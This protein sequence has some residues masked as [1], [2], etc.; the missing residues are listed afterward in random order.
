MTGRA[1]RAR[2]HIALGTWRVRQLCSLGLCGVAALSGCALLDRSAAVAIDRYKTPGEAPVNSWRVTTPDGGVVIF[3]TTRSFTDARAA[4]AAI[5]ATRLPV[6]GIFITHGHADHVTGI[7]IYR[8][9][10]PGVKVYASSTTQAY[11]SGTGR[12]LMAMNVSYRGSQDAAASVP[13]PDIL[14]SD[15]QHLTI[16][17]LAIDVHVIGPGESPDA[18]IYEIPA[19]RTVVV[20][21]LITR[22]RE[23]LVAEGRT[24][25]WLASIAR[26][27]R[28]YP[29]DES[30]LPGHGPQA[31]LG[32]AAKWQTAYLQ[33]YRA[34]ISRAIAVSSD[35]GRCVTPSET[36]KI[37]RSMADAFPV[38]QPVAKMPA[39]NLAKLNSEG[40]AWEFGGTTCPPIFNP[41]R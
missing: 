39:G 21:D 41:M 7:P 2:D 6:R 16:G 34:G 3:D 30:I 5:R 17:G 27:A 23:P 25:P 9:A 12:A 40:V 24:R 14:L 26:V 20:G 15:G 18:T 36:T 28:A 13:P 33:R 1:K 10:F 22:S 37:A 32:A 35:Q 29:Y 31:S 11:M 8:A 38:D 4:V 19:I